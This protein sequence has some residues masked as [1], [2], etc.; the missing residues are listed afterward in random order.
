MAFT[1][2]WFYNKQHEKKG[3]HIIYIKYA[4]QKQKI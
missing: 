4:I 1:L 2:S 3:E